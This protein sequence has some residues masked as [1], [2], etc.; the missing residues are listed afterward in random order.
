MNSSREGVHLSSWGDF[1]IHSLLLILALL[2]S[3]GFQTSSQALSL[4]HLAAP[5]LHSLSWIY[6]ELPVKWSWN[7]VL[8]NISLL[9][10]FSVLLRDLFILQ[11]VGLVFTYNFSN[12]NF[13]E[14]SNI[15]SEA[16]YPDLRKYLNG[17]PFDQIEFCENLTDCLMKIEYHTLNPI[18]GCPSLPEKTFALRTKGTLTKHCP[19]Y[20]ETQRNNTLDMKQDVKSICLNQTSQIQWLWFSLVQIPEY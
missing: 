13:K 5:V 15:Y 10:V 17:S 11:V 9:C 12:C 16:I 2:Q 18:P 20:S 19:G 6:K 4:T 1:G 3:E 7:W 14:I 8:V